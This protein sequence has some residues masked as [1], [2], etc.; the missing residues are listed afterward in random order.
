M[1][2]VTRRRFLA[3]LGIT[4]GAAATTT[5]AVA[6]EHAMRPDENPDLILIGGKIEGARN[7]YEAASA[8]LAAARARYEVL[9]PAAPD[10]LV[11]TYPDPFARDYAE[12]E[13]DLDNN[14]IGYGPPG[15]RET[16]EIIRS[17]HLERGMEATDGR[18]TKGRRIKRLLPIAHQYEQDIETA[19]EQSGWQEAWKAFYL[20]RRDL[21]TL[22]ETA[23]AA[24][25]LTMEGVEIKAKAILAALTT[26]EE[27]RFHPVRWGPAL[28]EAIVSVAGRAS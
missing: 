12:P 27:A 6:V 9:K 1:L 23:I 11:V 5:A 25:A 15:S 2:D 21:M 4:A 22:A 13:T 14:R 7:A 26:G 19:K 8:E 18:T 20:A 28:A 10:D 3:Q 16:K 24:D 17:Y